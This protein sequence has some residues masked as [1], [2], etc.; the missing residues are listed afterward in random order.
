MGF[1]TMLASDIKPESNELPVGEYTF[2]L[3]AKNAS[4]KQWKEDGPTQLSILAIVAE[5]EL[6]GRTS[7]LRWDDFT[8]EQYQADDKKEL[9]KFIKN[10]IAKFLTV[11]ST[12]RKPGENLLDYF[13]RVGSEEQPKFKATLED[14]S[15]TDKKTQEKKREGKVRF[16]PF[17]YVPAV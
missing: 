15:Y 12:E 7:F 10:D 8:H 6:K 1:E 5:G 17:S 16:K 3:G 11:F 4:Q 9:A 13:N 14:A 2:R